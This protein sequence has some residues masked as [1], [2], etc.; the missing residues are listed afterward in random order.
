MVPVADRV[1]PRVSQHD[2]SCAC[3][4][5]TAQ[6]PRRISPVSP[7]PTPLPRSIRTPLARYAEIVQTIFMGLILAFIFRAFFVEP[8]IIPTGSMA[9][10][11]LGAHAVRVCPACGWE[12]VFAPLPGQAPAETFLVPPEVVCPNCHQRIASTPEETIPR[13]GDRIL[14]HKWPLALGALLSPRTWDV[15]VFRDPSDYGQHFIKRV[16][17]RPHETVEIAGGD[18]FI[19]GRVLRKPAHVQAALWLVVFDQAHVPHHGAGAAR[20]A[21]WVRFPSPQDSGGGWDG[22]DTRVLHF[23]DSSSV[24]HTIEF[25]ADASPE[26]LVDFHAYNR[27]STHTFAGDVRLS[28]I[29]HYEQDTGAL[30]WTLER[31]P[32]VFTFE[33][34]P[35]GHLALSG[36][37][38][39]RALFPAGFGAQEPLPSFR[40]E[41][42]V[43]SFHPVRPRVVALEFVDYELRVQVDG[44]TVLRVAELAEIPFPPPI[45]YVRTHPLQAPVGLRLTAARTRLALHNLRIERDVV[46]VAHGPQNQRAAVGAPFQLQAGEYFVLGDNS[47]DSFDSREW[48]SGGVH[49]PPG[50]RPGTV[51]QGQIV[52]QAAFVYLPG[53]LPL[54]RSGRWYVP[55]LGRVRFVR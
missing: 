39:D 8:F 7:E 37:C 49:L 15:V 52:G 48:T 26:Y 51:L 22:L 32:Y 38:L 11:L 2:G 35:D 23:D 4:L 33:I 6:V 47:A 27:R 28:A 29:V 17:G 14:V 5:A 31:P 20:H 36:A 24:S 34:P 55:D 40:R 43:G 50:Y 9:N 12:F 19:N 30:V 53:L 45:E 21:R 18:V 16:V 54:D 42:A 25:N 3:D 46:Y 10:G 1:D 44:R 41:V 13:S